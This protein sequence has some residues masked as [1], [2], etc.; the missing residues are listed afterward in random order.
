MKEFNEWK[1]DTQKAIDYDTSFKFYFPLTRPAA[2]MLPESVQLISTPEATAALQRLPASRRNVVVSMEQLAMPTGLD[3]KEDYRYN[4]LSHPEIAAEIAKQG[5]A[6]RNQMRREE[7]E[8]RIYQ[9]EAISIF[10]QALERNF[11]DKYGKNGSNAQLAQAQ[12]APTSRNWPSSFGSRSDGPNRPPDP[13]RAPAPISIP[14]GPGM[15][16]SSATPKSAL[17]SASSDK[18][19]DMRDAPQQTP[20]QAS[21]VQIPVA[22]APVHVPAQPGMSRDPRKPPP[23]FNPYALAREE[24]THSAP[25]VSLPARREEPLH[26]NPYG[27]REEPLP[28]TGPL[29]PYGRREGRASEDLYSRRENVQPQRA[30]AYSNPFYSKQSP[31]SPSLPGGRPGQSPASPASEHSAGRRTSIQ[32]SRQGSGGSV[33][34]GREGA[35]GANVSRWDGSPRNVDDMDTGEAAWLRRKSM[36]SGNL[37]R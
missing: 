12:S 23:P 4:E 36:S 9:H 28:P 17:F 30:V 6:M 27:R 25:P 7:Q 31:M 22:P 1:E 24:I 16:S 34:V 21:A 15:V 8:M 2:I 13:R 29:N 32:M 14:K 33:I 11:P 18:D 5:V 3:E 35:L 26:S 10:L 19:T 20:Q 37:R